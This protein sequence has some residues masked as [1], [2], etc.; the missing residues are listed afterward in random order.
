[1]AEDN[2]PQPISENVRAAF[3][4]EDL[5]DPVRTI[6]R[7]YELWRHWADFHLYINT[8]FIPAIYPPI[9]HEPELVPGTNELE[10][11]YPIHDEGFKLSASKAEDMFSAGMSMYKLFM[12]IEKMIFLL[13]ERLKSG[14]VDKETEV[15]VAFGGHIIAQR[16]AFE[17]VI[18]LSYNVVVTNFDPGL[19]GEQYLSIIKN[20]AAKDYGYPSETPRDSYRVSRGSGAKNTRP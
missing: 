15:Q 14:G 9:L 3:M 7:V 5:N 19:W 16:K 18:N 2:K 1:M 4:K 6:E 13:I 8:P 11:V 17:S 12:T 10:F 20:L